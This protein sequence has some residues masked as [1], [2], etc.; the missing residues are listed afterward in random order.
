M[1]S[2][3]TKHSPNQNT[4]FLMK[5]L[6]AVLHSV[7]ALGSNIIAQIYTLEQACTFVLLSVF[8]VF[9]TRLAFTEI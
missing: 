3:L 7:T 9:N 4:S 5:I 1:K 2:I 8:K 6:C